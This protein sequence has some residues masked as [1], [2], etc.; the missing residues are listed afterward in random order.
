[1]MMLSCGA[2]VVTAGLPMVQRKE[3]ERAVFVA[4]GGRGFVVRCNLSADR[5]ADAKPG[6][7]RMLALIAFLG[8]S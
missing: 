7:P 4:R 8:G 2:E 5:L 3:S 6:K 1:L